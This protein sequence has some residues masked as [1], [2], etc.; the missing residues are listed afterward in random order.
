MQSLFLSNFIIYL[1]CV[2]QYIAIIHFICINIMKNDNE[3][4]VIGVRNMVSLPLK[5]SEHTKIVTFNYSGVD[6]DH[7]AI[8]FGDIDYRLPVL[9]RVHSECV[10]GDLLGSLRCDCGEQLNQAIDSLSNRGGILIYLRQEGRGI[11]LGLKIDAYR[12]Q[13]VGLDTYEANSAL[14][15]PADGRCYTLAAEMLKAINVS[16][17]I[18]MT[19][20][21]DKTTQLGCCGIFVDSVIPTDTF[22][23]K[24][25]RKY[26][27]AKASKSKHNINL[28]GLL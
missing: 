2:K 14:T 11:G 17:I 27:Y 10:T 28:D 9:V 21:P 7:F 16:H 8:V 3:Q 12:L 25:N 13:D 18:L 20:N 15:L 26:L 19:N 22:V 1:F 4:C 5:S 24:F 6:C 23:T